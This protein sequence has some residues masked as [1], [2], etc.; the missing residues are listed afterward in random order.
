MRAAHPQAGEI[1]AMAFAFEAADAIA[2]NFP[3]AA[4]KSVEAGHWLMID[5]LEEVARLLLAEG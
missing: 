2:A 3:H 5:K 4:V 1:L